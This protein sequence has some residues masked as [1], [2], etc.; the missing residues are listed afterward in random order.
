M[1]IG[2]S[3]ARRFAAIVGVV[4]VLVVGTIVGA[5]RL[6]PSGGQSGPPRAV[7]VDQLALTDENSVFVDEASQLLADAGYQVDYVPQTNVTVDF[8][9][10]LAKRGY[11]FIVL[12]THTSDASYRIDQAT[13]QTVKEDHVRIFTNELYSQQKYVNDQLDARLTIGTY[14]QFGS[15]DR[16][17]SIDP[18]FV[19]DAMSGRF[20][21]ATIVLMGCGGLNT[22][23]MGQAFVGKGA[24]EL[25]GWDHS[26]S[27][28]HTDAATERLLEHMLRDGMAAPDAISRTMD[29]VGPDPTYGARLKLYPDA[30]S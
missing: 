28:E 27:A 25:V 4:A 7:I 5:W 2:R 29:E 12:R 20:H 21:G 22:A 19:Q 23:D 18:G 26:V 24:K 6:W 16:Y 10:G 30:A 13:G 14:P 3:S 9:R 17:F 1:K 11:S 15:R 8:Y